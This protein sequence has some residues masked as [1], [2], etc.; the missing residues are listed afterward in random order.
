MRT[1]KIEFY[2]SMDVTPEIEKA[3]M[4]ALDELDTVDFVSSSMMFRD[5]EVDHRIQV[6]PQRLAKKG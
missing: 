2:G 3:I 6:Y 4:S 5:G 1:I